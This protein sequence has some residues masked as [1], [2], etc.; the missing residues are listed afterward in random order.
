MKLTLQM[1]CAFNCSFA[2]CAIRTFTTELGKDSHGR[3]SPADMQRRFEKF[4]ELFELE[5]VACSSSSARSFHRYV[6]CKTFNKS[7]KRLLDQFNKRWARPELKADWLREFSPDAWRALDNAARLS[8]DMSD[9]HACASAHPLLHN[10]FPHKV[11]PLSPPN[12]MSVVAKRLADD[13]AKVK[14]RQRQQVAH[15]CLEELQTSFHQNYGTNICQDWNKD[16]TTPLTLP[17]TRAEQV[18]KVRDGDRRLKRKAEEG[19]FSTDFNELYGDF[20]SKSAYER[21]R[22]NQA[23]GSWEDAEER[24]KRRMDGERRKTAV[25]VN[26][27]KYTWSW[28]ALVEDAKTW[29]PGKKINWQEVARQYAVHQAN[30]TSKL[31]ANGGQIVRAVLED[32]GIETTQF[33]S[34]TGK[35]TGDPRARRAAK[36]TAQGIALPAHTPVANLEKEK[37]KKYEEGVLCRPIPIAPRQYTQESINTSTGKLESTTKTVHGQKVPLHPLL[38]NTLDS[39]AKQK[40]LAMQHVDPDSDATEVIVERLEQLGQA[41][42]RMYS[43]YTRTIKKQQNYMPGTSNPTENITFSHHANEAILYTRLLVWIQSSHV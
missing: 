21:R 13:V 4:E 41:S 3:L 1:A 38:K 43:A 14:D 7:C 6:D 39:L 16:P 26:Y 15:N 34:G 30:D 36:R 8:H 2:R 10:A 31:A 25:T 9:C 20:T 19:Y 18:L 24:K 37:E 22:R 28:Q 40:L 35:Q 29:A 12:T 27:E 23:L 11:T 42:T 32:N 17:P 5:D 33:V